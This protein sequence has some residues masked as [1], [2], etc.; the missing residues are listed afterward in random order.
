MTKRQGQ[1]GIPLANQQLQVDSM[2]AAGILSSLELDGKGSQSVLSYRDIC[3]RM[4]SS[5]GQC[6]LKNLNQ[7]N[8]EGKLHIGEANKK[9]QDKQTPC[10]GPQCVRDLNKVAKRQKWVWWTDAGRGVG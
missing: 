6:G 8:C 1:I 2:H 4:T 9:H 10:T 7:N 3:I 5:V